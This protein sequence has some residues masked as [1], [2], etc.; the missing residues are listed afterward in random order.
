MVLT[1]LIT[2]PATAKHIDKNTNN[3]NKKK[4]HCIN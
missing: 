1:L 3:Y 2:R 4:N